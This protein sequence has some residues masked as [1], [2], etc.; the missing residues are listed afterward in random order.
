MSNYA[1]GANG[2]IPSD[3]QVDSFIASAAEKKSKLAPAVSWA[4]AAQAHN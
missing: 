4:S 1:A 3:A 2:P